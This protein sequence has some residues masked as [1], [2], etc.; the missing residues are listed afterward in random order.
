[1][2][3]IKSTEEL[4]TYIE[5]QG[6]KI[7]DCPYLVHPRLGYYIGIFVDEPY[8]L[9]ELLNSEDKVFC[10]PLRGVNVQEVVMCVWIN[11]K[12][13]PFLNDIINPI[14]NTIDI[15]EYKVASNQIEKEIKAIVEHIDCLN[16]SIRESYLR[17]KQCNTL[18]L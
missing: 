6:I 18:N 4:I 9:E 10:M 12:L 1:M 17:W 11:V 13:I 2:R 15:D 3:N 8:K 16:E 14:L 7:T 5:S